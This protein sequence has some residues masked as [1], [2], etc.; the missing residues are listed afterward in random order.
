MMV[1]AREGEGTQI[2]RT[3]HAAA[4]E[5]L[6]NKVLPVLRQHLPEISAMMLLHDH[7]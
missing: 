1:I 7:D 2:V 5:A 4:T 6:N 3:I